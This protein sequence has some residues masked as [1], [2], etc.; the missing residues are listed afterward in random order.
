MTTSQNTKSHCPKCG[1]PLELGSSEPCPVCLLQLAAQSDSIFD[2][3]AQSEHEV[4]ASA[5]AKLDLAVVQ[6]AFPQLEI[7]EQI[8][9]GGMGTVF[10]ARQ[11][12][13]DR[14]VALKILSEQLA[15][16]PTFAERFAQEGKLL[17]RLNHPN[18][19]AVY[20]FGQT[21]TT[22]DAGN[23]FSFFFLILEYVDGVNLRQAMR[24]AR[25]SPEQALAIVP[26]ICEA[27]QYA[28]EEGVLHRDIKPENILLD[29]KGRIKIAD[30]GIAGVA[31]WTADGATAP[32]SKPAPDG[33]WNLPAERLTQTGVVL[34]TPSYMAPEQLVTPGKV[35]HRADIYSLGV[36]FYELLTGELPKES[37]GSLTPPSAKTPVGAEI[38]GIVLKALNRD[39]T[40]RH[41]SVRELKTEI[42][43][44]TR[45]SSKASTDHALNLP[46]K[47]SKPPFWVVFLIFLGILSLLPHVGK[48]IEKITALT[49]EG[50][51]GDGEAVIDSLGT[52][53]F[54]IFALAIIWMGIHW[55]WHKN[56]EN[57]S[58]SKQRRHWPVGIVALL[59][60]LI[61]AVSN[62]IG[63]NVL[64]FTSWVDLRYPQSILF[65]MIVQ[66][67][68]VG[69]AIF[70]YKV[71]Q[72][73][74][75]ILKYFALLAG[76][77][78]LAVF[79]FYFGVASDPQMGI[80]L[81]FSPLYSLPFFLMG[82]VVAVTINFTV[83]GIVHLFRYG[84]SVLTRGQ[85]NMHSQPL[86]NA[87]LP[88][89]PTRKLAGWGASLVLASFLI[90][91]IG[92]G[93]IFLV[94]A[95]EAKMQFNQRKQQIQ[96]HI[97]RIV[98]Y[99]S[100]IARFRLDI[101]KSTNK[102]DRDTLQSLIESFE[103]DKEQERQRFEREQKH[104]METDRTL[105][106]IG[107]IVFNLIGLGLAVTGTV[108]GWRYLALVR[109]G[110]KK[111]AILAGYFAALAFP[112]VNLVTCFGLLTNW[113][114]QQGNWGA[115]QNFVV[116]LA[117]TGGV[118]IGI[119]L[120]IFLINLTVRWVSGGTPV[121]ESSKM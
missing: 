94:R 88:K 63:S 32:L 36:V 114:F 90:P 45:V 89:R 109:G 8:G 95:S 110:E 76:W 117:S 48:L 100:R 69:F 66:L 28:H 22:D 91:V 105:F 79:H 108:F 39:R 46:T 59:T 71:S 11:P 98:D 6:K 118:M 80:A 15:E 9:R 50:K 85:T 101:Q 64:G 14:F 10:K 20:D 82:H 87:G 25:F 13:L 96:Q 84:R 53:F 113:I 41:Q 51:W 40:Q 43:T 31:H 75:G 26:K 49:K 74:W 12:N 38:D 93:M 47:Q 78:F 81:M 97:T 42:E 30:F 44:V 83:V 4:L 104:R 3:S 77:G 1:V 70:F 72:H 19:V 7:I 33:R 17:A 106:F 37:L 5:G 54:G 116:A 102:Q 18:I 2:S 60:L 112:L 29:T 121:K 99:D 67:I 21:E 111:P 61:S 52:E 55:H 119:A 24:E 58:L 115:Q 34:G 68:A 56:R 103:R 86:E 16:K 120:A 27:L 23:T 35:D 73:L 57:N 62:L 107:T 92:L 65:A